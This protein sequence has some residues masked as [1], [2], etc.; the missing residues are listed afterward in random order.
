MEFL[1][2]LTV[3]LNKSFM[4]IT[5]HCLFLYQMAHPEILEPKKGGWIKQAYSP[6]SV[7]SL[8]PTIVLNTLICY[9]SLEAT[10]LIP[11]PCTET[12]SMTINSVHISGSHKLL[13]SITGMDVYFN[14]CSTSMMLYIWLK[15]YSSDLHYQEACCCVCSFS[16]CD[17]LC[18][19][20][21]LGI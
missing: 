2:R 17:L 10:P 1:S 3:S 13:I 19:V 8:W 14:Y 20:D 5:C 4:I 7:D 15:V 21:I 11:R 18:A 16:C 9:N 12:G 6:W